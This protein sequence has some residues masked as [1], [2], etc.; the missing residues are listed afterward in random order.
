MRNLSLHLFKDYGNYGD[1]I[2]MELSYYLECSSLA[3]SGR[4]GT[5]AICQPN[6]EYTFFIKCVYN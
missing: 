2:D 5:E 3:R 4:S 6:G 1:C